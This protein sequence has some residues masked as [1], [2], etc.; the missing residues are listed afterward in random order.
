M[1]KGKGRVEKN[2]VLFKHV[3]EPVAEISL[4]APDES[5]DSVGSAGP[6]T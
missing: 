1:G 6:S 2:V 5:S 3:V 4:L